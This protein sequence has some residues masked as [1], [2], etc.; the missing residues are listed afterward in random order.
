MMVYFFIVDGIWA[1]WGDWQNCTLDTD[2]ICQQ[3]DKSFRT[4]DCTDPEP[5]FGGNECPP[6]AHMT[7][8][9]GMHVYSV[10][11]Q[12]DNYSY[13]EI[14][15]LNLTDRLND[16]HFLISI[17]TDCF[18]EGSWNVVTHSRQACW[19]FSDEAEK[20]YDD[21]LAHCRTLASDLAGL[22]VISDNSL[23]AVFN[24]IVAQ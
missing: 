3:D 2:S 10:Q 8:D 4:R 18:I 5:Q 20:N 19:Y 22:A 23:L 15:Q 17:L 7:T 6:S 21:A 13:C 12:Q 14:K 16:F 24:A 11:R 1:S 9:I